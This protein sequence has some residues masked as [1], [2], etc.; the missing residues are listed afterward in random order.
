MRCFLGCD[1]TPQSK[2]ALSE[3]CEHFARL[4]ASGP[5][6]VRPANYHVTSLF[7]GHLTSSQLETV[8]TACANM[9]EEQRTPL[10]AFEIALNDIVFW[11]KPKIMAAIPLSVHPT[12]LALHKLALQVASEAK[13]QVKHPSSS[14]RPHV[15]L[16]R[17]VQGDQIAPPL[18]MPDIKFVV[19]QW[20]LFESVSTPSGV[21]YPIRFS[22]DF[23]PSF[24][25]RRE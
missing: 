4:S 20:H 24:A 19:N 15:T 13:I 5:V 21:T 1:L 25:H 14:Y 16:Y 18:L 3:W 7:L 2:I 12:L 11:Q 22:W 8:V 23:S 10:H 6:K 17:K 9:I